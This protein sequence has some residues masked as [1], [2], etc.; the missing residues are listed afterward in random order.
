MNSSEL[1]NKISAILTPELESRNWFLVDCKVNGGTVQ[2]FVDSDK[3][4][5]IENCATISRF[6]EGELDKEFNFSS[7]YSL[8][9]SS[10]GMG[11]PLKVLRQYRK[12]AG[13][14]V[15]V[16]LN[17]GSRKEGRLV[18]SNDNGI[19]LEEIKTEKK[20]QTL[21]GQI[22]INFNQIKS[23]TVVVEFK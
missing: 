17:D 22:E 1:Q 7:S 9:V 21:L 2:V 16:L 6:L 12:Y 23:T 13:R 19:L 14:K 18:S 20:K 15:S 10:P 11:K 4:F 8:E 3:G 5:T